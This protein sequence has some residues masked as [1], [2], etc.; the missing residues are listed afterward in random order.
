MPVLCLK[1]N[2]WNLKARR[3]VGE[4]EPLVPDGAVCSGQRCPVC[5]GIDLRGSDALLCD[6]VCF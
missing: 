1:A 3:T 6:E 2:T 4:E 5:E